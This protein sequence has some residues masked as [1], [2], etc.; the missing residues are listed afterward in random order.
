MTPLGEKERV[1]DTL[2]NSD[3]YNLPHLSKAAKAES[4]RV[5]T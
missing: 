1:R 2:D 5:I 4:K 3:I